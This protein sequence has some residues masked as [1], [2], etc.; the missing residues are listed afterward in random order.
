MKALVTMLVV[1]A[2]ALFGL[3]CE[4]ATWKVKRGDTLGSISKKT[5]VSVKE[6]AAANNLKN[7]NLIRAGQCLTIPEKQAAKATPVVKSQTIVVREAAA[8]Q[9]KVQV[10]NLRS[11]ATV[12]ATAAQSENYTLSGTRAK[13]ATEKE[14]DAMLENMT[15][16]NLAKAREQNATA[17]LA[18]APVPIESSAR[19]SKEEGVH[20]FFEFDATVGGW[21]S[22]K[23]TRGGYAFAEGMPWFGVDK[24]GNTNLGV[25]A[26]LAV[27]HGTGKNGAK[28]GY[29]NPGLELGWWQN[30]DDEFFF[31]L[32]PRVGYRWNEK[33]NFNDK[34]QSGPTVGVYSDISRVFTPRDLGIIALDATYFKNDS[35]G[36]LR[37]YWEHMINNDWKVKTGAGASGH[38]QKDDKLIGFSP[39]VS[40]KFRDTIS[41]GVIGDFSSKVTTVGMNIMYEFNSDRHDPL[42]LQKK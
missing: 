31:L 11:D 25:G 19:T 26:T 4:A 41:V 8:P 5:G 21:L 24:S 39:V 36:A 20:K 42:R 3:N 38:F 34:P 15:T 33:N 14:T 6:I 18:E 2:V 10:T 7:R 1:L 32:K 29:I 23:S 9:P 16:G 40:F 37:V 12:V 28:W 27:D 35:Q 13:N 30:F 17:A 22:N